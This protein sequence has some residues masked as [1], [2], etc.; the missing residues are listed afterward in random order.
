MELLLDQPLVHLTVKPDMTGTAKR[1]TA[2]VAVQLE[3]CWMTAEQ[4]QAVTR[5]LANA[6]TDSKAH[7]ADA[8][9]LELALAAPLQLDRSAEIVPP[10]VLGPQHADAVQQATGRCLPAAL[11]AGNFAASATD[12][13]GL[14][15]GFQGLVF[16]T[17]LWQHVPSIA[18]GQ[19]C[20]QPWS[21]A[22]RPERLAYW[23]LLVQP[24][25]SQ[26][27]DADEEAADA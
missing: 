27:P 10:T 11:Q 15:A 25:P 24:P 8:A 20:C 12:P 9:A 26:S 13:T 4:H 14:A 5:Q 22:V 2:G 17:R 1:Q 3:D 7:W 6:L 19:S 16:P 23:G 18:A 21:I